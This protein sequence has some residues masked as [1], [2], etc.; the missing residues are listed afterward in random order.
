MTTRYDPERIRSQLRTV[1]VERMFRLIHTKHRRRPLGVV[2]A[3]SRFSD[4]AGK[5]AVLYAAEAVRCSFWEALARNRFT[6]RKRRVLPRADVEAR[7]VVSLRSTNTLQLVDLRGD[8]PI[9]ISAPAAVAHDANHAASRALSSAAYA[10]VSEA[11]G[12]LFQSRFTGH[13]CAAVFD[14]GI[15]NLETIDITRLIE[16]ADFLE[17][18][19]DYDITLAS[20]RK[21][22]FVKKC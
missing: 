16:H 21:T 22:H 5:Y 12:F 9:R 20:M 14:R 19:E 2:P 15:K 8:G 18:M 1:R 3:P 11:D 10:G 13:I 6:R 7:L 17:A 4:P